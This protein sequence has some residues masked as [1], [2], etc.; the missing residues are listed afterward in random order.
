LVTRAINAFGAGAT[1]GRIAA[2]RVVA[3][4]VSVRLAERNPS[5]VLAEYYGYM[6]RNPTDAPD[7]GDEGFQFWLA[8][9]NSL[10]GDFIKAEMV[11]AFIASK[12]YRTR[13]GQP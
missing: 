9:L 7:F 3:D 2:L 5:F 4:A 6:R 10:G 1:A 8:K 11:K 12:E 13:F